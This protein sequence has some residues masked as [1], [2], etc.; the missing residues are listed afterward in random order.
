M[1]RTRREAHL[2]DRENGRE[3]C[4]ISSDAQGAGVFESGRSIETTGTVVVA[5]DLAT[6]VGKE[7]ER[8]RSRSES[9]EKLTSRQELGDRNTLALSSRD[10]ANVVVTDFCVVRVPQ[11]KERSENV[12]ATLDRLL[13][14]IDTTFLCGSTRGRSERESLL[15]S[16]EWHV[17]VVCNRGKQFN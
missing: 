14:R 17:D 10:T 16:Q 1:R 4:D 2:V 3:I 7:G 13:P 11:S 6:C 9:I 15:D 8:K 5:S 12:S